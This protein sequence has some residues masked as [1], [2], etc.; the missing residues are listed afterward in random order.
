MNSPYSLAPTP[1]AR[2][3]ARRGQRV[4]RLYK[5][6]LAGRAPKGVAMPIVVQKYGGSSVADVEKIRKVAQK[7]KARREEGFEL[8]I[9]MNAI[10]VVFFQ[11]WVARK[12][13]SSSQC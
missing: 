11:F 2:R 3:A 10:I 9:S 12:L 1:G 13:E 5:V 4:H 8:L 7:V 6:G